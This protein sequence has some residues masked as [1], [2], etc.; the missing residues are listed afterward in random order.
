[1]YLDLNLPSARPLRV[2][3]L[4]PELAPSARRRLVLSLR[5]A[6]SDAASVRRIT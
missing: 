4:P 2:W 5:R 6:L 3:L 1:L